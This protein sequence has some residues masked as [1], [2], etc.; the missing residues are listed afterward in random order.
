VYATRILKGENPNDL[1]A[2]QITKF[3][4]EIKFETAKALRLAVSPNLLAL[5]E[6]IE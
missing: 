5:A 1:L 6:V 4:F 2:I 3:E